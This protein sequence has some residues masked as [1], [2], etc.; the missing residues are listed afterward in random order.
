MSQNLFKWTEAQ[1]IRAVETSC[2]VWQE[3]LHLRDI[4]V[5]VAITDMRDS[6]WL[7]VS[8]DNGYENTDCA[9]ISVAHSALRHTT[10]HE[11][12]SGALHELLHVMLWPMSLAIEHLKT[13]FL[14]A[15]QYRMIDD[16]LHRGNEAVVY[17]LER[18]WMAMPHMSVYLPSPEAGPEFFEP[19]AQI[20]LRWPAG[21]VPVSTA[22]DRA[23]STLPVSGVD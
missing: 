17:K 16:A 20:S 2:R 7:Q 5:R 4:T 12:F 1:M 14:A 19:S 23:V 3:Q 22:S 21:N 9:Y 13:N 10:A 18:L 15:S 6:P 8:A 11:V